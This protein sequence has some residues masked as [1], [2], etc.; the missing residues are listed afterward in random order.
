MVVIEMG[1]E[2]SIEETSPRRI[3]AGVVM[4]EP[5]HKNVRTVVRSTHRVLLQPN[6]LAYATNFKGMGTANALVVTSYTT[7]LTRRAMVVLVE[8][9]VEVV[10]CL[11]M[12][13]RSRGDLLLIIL[14][15]YALIQLLVIILSYQYQ[16]KI[17]LYILLFLHVIT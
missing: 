15:R 17:I 13:S 4:T 12:V 14:Y 2:A 8:A 3:E 9:Q 11:Q 7:T 5:R 1:E 10:V 16:L 6:L